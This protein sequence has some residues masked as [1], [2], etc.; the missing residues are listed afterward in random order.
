MVKGEERRTPH[1]ESKNEQ[2]DNCGE[3]KKKVAKS[4]YSVKKCSE[5]VHCK[6]I[7]IS[8]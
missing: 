4:S 6:P 3:Y 8:L 7:V 2:F 5:C 1:F